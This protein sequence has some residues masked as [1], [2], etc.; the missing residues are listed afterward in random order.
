MSLSSP[1]RR[2]V[3]AATLALVAV[4]GAAALLPAAPAQAAPAAVTPTTAEDEYGFLTKIN[5]ER[6][7][8][9]LRKL[10][11]DGELASTSRS[12]SAYMARQGKI[13]HDPNLAQVASR[14]EPDWRRIGE[15]VGVGH[16]VQS[17][18]DAFMASSGHRANILGAS[19]NRVGIGVVHSDGKI[20]VTVRFLEG[21]AISGSTGGPTPPPGVKTALTGDFDGDGYEDLLSYNPGTTVDELWFG[22]PDGTMTQVA[23]DVD[24]QHRPVAG[25][26]D[27]DGRTQVLW[28]TPGSFADPMWEWDGDS[29]VTTTK[30]INGT[31]KPLVGDFDGDDRDDLLWYAAGTAADSYWYGNYDGSFSTYGS[32]INGSYRP[33]VGDLDG[34]GGADLFWYAPGT[35][36]DFMWYSTLRRGSYAN[37]ATTVNGTY[38]PFTGDF[39][40]SGTDDLFWYAPGTA[41]DFTW[42]TTRT[43]GR[44]TSVAR[45]VVNTYVPSAADFD[46]DTADDIVWFTPAPAG[47]DPVWF[48]TDGAKTYSLSS[49]H[50]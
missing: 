34:N 42:Y 4:L 1:L 43:Q 27:G 48:G 18:H 11:S 35:S 19:Y 37:K 15:N 10:V 46:G 13:S 24:G 30:A 29:W 47:G 3:A 33:T 49:V 25:D 17:L 45:K 31:Y 2:I 41:N 26:F 21:P 9:G 23:V 22:E 8:R 38:R 16:T 5:Q 36:N 28:Y 50:G 20:W 12:W 44:Y 6:A 7:Y 40:G 32:T 14:V 39:D